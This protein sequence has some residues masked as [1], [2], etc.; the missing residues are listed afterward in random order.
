MTPSRD[1]NAAPSPTV[2][3]V[4]TQRERFSPTQA[5]LDSVYENTVMPFEFIYVDG[6]SPLPI[7]N[8]LAERSAVYGFR[9]LR[10]EH[11]LT[12]N[13]AR[14]LA[15]GMVRSSHVCFLDNDVIAFPGWL[16]RLVACAEETGAD[17]VGPLYGIHTRREG[18][19]VHTTSGLFRSTGRAGRRSYMYRLQNEGRPLEDPDL[20]RDRY[21]C[22]HVEFHCMLVSSALV[23]SIGGLDEGFRS[24]LD[25]VDLCLSAARAGAEI[26]SEPSAVVSYLQPPPVTR[27]DL[28]FF[29]WRWS[30]AWNVADGRHFAAKWGFRS[31]YDHRIWVRYHRSLSYEWL[32]RAVIRLVGER[33]AIALLA[34]TL[35]P[36]ESLG[37]RVLFR[38]LTRRQRA[39]AESGAALGPS[40]A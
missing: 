29:M 13:E 30:E 3:I 28:P 9:H 24:S 35:F 37:N 15:L 25:H 36:V 8:F 19:R 12:Q 1:A 11:F 27:T 39:R 16:E 23:R 7:R 10:R 38:L 21:R 22:E 5:S 14:N 40:G 6:G 20:P 17:V 33:L 26:W 18:H 34:V 4:M 31:R 2:T 32:P